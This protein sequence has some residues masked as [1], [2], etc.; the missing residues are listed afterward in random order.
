LLL[1]VFLASYRRLVQFS[2][3]PLDQFPPQPQ[4]IKVWLHPFYVRH[5]IFGVASAQW[6][7]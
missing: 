7:R 1:P 5:K 6:R 4:I 3:A 2:S